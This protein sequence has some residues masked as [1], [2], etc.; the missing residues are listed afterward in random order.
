MTG[1]KYQ[2]WVTNVNAGPGQKVTGT[3]TLLVNGRQVEN[4]TAE[5]L[6]NAVNAAG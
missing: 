6:K 2:D 3:P 4:P 1:M 5:K